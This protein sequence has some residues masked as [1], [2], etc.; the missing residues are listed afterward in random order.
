MQEYSQEYEFDGAVSMRLQPFAYHCTQSPTVPLTL[1]CAGRI[2]NLGLTLYLVPSGLSLAFPA[3]YAP[4]NGFTE[5]SEPVGA[6]IEGC[7]SEAGQE[8]KIVKREWLTVQG[9]FGMIMD[10]R[11]TELRF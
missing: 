10:V 4:E 6:R 2:A 8:R 11:K 3:Q 9:V 1:L 5:K 7:L